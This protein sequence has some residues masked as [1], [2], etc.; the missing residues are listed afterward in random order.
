MRQLSYSRQICVVLFSQQ[1]RYLLKEGRARERGRE[2]GRSYRQKTKGCHRKTKEDCC[3]LKLQGGLCGEDEIWAGP[4]KKDS[5][6]GMGRTKECKGRT[7]EKRWKQKRELVFLL[8][9]ARNIPSGGKLKSDNLHF[10]C[11][12]KESEIRPV[13]WH[14]E[15]RRCGGG[16]FLFSKFPKSLWPT[17]HLNPHSLTFS[18]LEWT[19]PI[20]IWKPYLT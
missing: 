11:L 8:R 17:E 6:V 19:I 13:F 16:K 3:E 9:F 7:I 12:D 5:Y 4:W 15:W 1:V 10:T 2:G 18:P 20:K 14:K